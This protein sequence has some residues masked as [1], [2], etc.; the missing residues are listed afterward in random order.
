VQTGP[1]TRFFVTFLY[2]FVHRRCKIY[3]S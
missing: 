2:W 1:K 3:S